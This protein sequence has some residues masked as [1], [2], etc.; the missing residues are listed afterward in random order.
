MKNI[1]LSE[2]TQHCASWKEWGNLMRKQLLQNRELMIIW[3]GT[4]ISESWILAISLS[5]STY[6]MSV[7]FS[8]N[9]VV[10]KELEFTI[11]KSQ[12]HS[13]SFVQQ[14]VIKGETGFSTH[15]FFLMLF[16]LLYM[17]ILSRPTA[18]GSS[19]AKD[20]THTTVV[21][22]ATALTTLNS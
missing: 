15:P 10:A 22:R 20:R 12:W 7:C 6:P 19:W 1:T 2:Q 9:N 11:Q 17:Y 8:F 21:T 18:S 5:T 14:S 3:M 4:C 13:N 16:T